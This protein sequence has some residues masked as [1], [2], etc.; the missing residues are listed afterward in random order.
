M[1]I[2]RLYQTWEDALTY[3]YLIKYQNLYVLLDIVCQQRKQ[4]LFCNVSLRIFITLLCDPL[5]SKAL[6]NV[7]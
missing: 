6:T 5:S 3:M 2:I 1:S 7:Y 4:H